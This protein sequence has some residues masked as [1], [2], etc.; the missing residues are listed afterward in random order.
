[1]SDSRKRLA[2][3]EQA[4]AARLASQ[5]LEIPDLGEVDDLGWP[6]TPAGWALL[7]EHMALLMQAAPE[8]QARLER[9]YGSESLVP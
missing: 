9:V 7:N 1:M 8:M 3:L 4:S 2:A 6:V 5:R